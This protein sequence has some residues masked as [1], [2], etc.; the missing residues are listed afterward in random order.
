MFTSLR[1]R[2]WL[3]YALLVFVALV[4][5]AVVLFGFLLTNPLVYRQATQHINQAQKIILDRQDEWSSLP[6]TQMALWLTRLAQTPI[7]Q[8]YGV[9]V[10]VFNAQRGLIA[11]SQ[12][13]AAR[14]V[15]PRLP[16]LRPDGVV[17]DANNN[18]WLY[19]L[20][21]LKNDD[22]LLVTAPRPPVPVAAILSDEF[23]GPI[24]RAGVVALLLSL[25]LAYL[26]ARWVA[27]PLQRLVAASHQV[28]NV[29]LAA[30]PQG[31]PREVQDLVSA[32]KAMLG[33]VQSSQQSQRD[34]VANV[35]HEMKTPLTSIQGFA[36][37]ILDGTAQTPSEQQQAAEIIYSEAGRMHRMVV[38]LLDLARLDAGTAKFTFEPLDLMALLRNVGEKFA[39]QARQAGVTLQVQP[40]QQ[41]A[42]LPLVP[43]D[44]DRL[45][46]VLTNL[47]DNALR[48]TP[49]GGQV[50]L[51]ASL[52]P[53]AICATVSDTGEGIS[54]EALPHIFERFYRADPSR[55]GGGD[56]GAGLGLAI[57]REIA[58]AHH[59]TLTA[60]SQPG[61]GSTFT[62][63]LPITS[64][65]ATTI[66][67]RKRK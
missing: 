31:G 26:V 36:Q 20:N 21:K 61:R 12:A 17:R 56:H 51:S 13:D 54:P 65:D 46:Q 53:D 38:N 59:G 15:L 33:R 64:P 22:W 24:L 5:V 42:G 63:R 14:L 55:R 27:D 1:A 43:G 67:R 49:S 23:F 41:D 16:R 50:L 2:L 8:E 25:V 4:V 66:I 45:T 48:H 6:A 30:L 28:P 19:S 3:S 9:R 32:Y 35:S 29:D 34:F 18:P 62:L 37:A 10:L 39:L 52:E 58:L 60:E 7:G 11:D 47:V 44:G 40:A 57:A